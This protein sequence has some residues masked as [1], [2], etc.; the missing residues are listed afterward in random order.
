M[1]W[2]KVRCSTNW[3][4]Q[5]SFPLLILNKQEQPPVLNCLI[6]IR[7]FA[8]Y[9]IY[10]ACLMFTNV[11]QG[12]NV[13]LGIERCVQGHTIGERGQDWTHISW[14]LTTRWSD[15]AG[16]PPDCTASNHSTLPHTHRSMAHTAGV[17][18][19]YSWKS[20]RDYYFGGIL[21]LW[22]L[23]TWLHTLLLPMWQKVLLE[24]ICSNGSCLRKHICVIV[25]VAN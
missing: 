7:F 21:I 2:A 22:Y 17:S 16:A 3:V 25:W 1:T 5:A 20:S 19:K 10:F 8:G 6:W 18:G 14:T 9:L 13:C 24:H 23:K 11:V 4:T 15:A 12:A